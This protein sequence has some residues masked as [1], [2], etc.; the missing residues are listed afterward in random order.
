MAQPPNQ[1]CFPNNKKTKNGGFLSHHGVPPV[2][3][4][5]LVGFPL[6]K[7]I[8]RTGGSPWCERVTA[9]HGFRRMPRFRFRPTGLPLGIIINHWSTI[10]KITM[11]HMSHISCNIHFSGVFHCKP[12]IFIH[13]QMG[14]LPAPPA[15]P[16][17]PAELPNPL[18]RSARG[19]AEEAS[20]PL[21]PEW[22][23][24][25]GLEKWLVYVGLSGQILPKRWMR[26]GAGCCCLCYFFFMDPYWHHSPNCN[27]LPWPR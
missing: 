3:I 26:T 9:F 10:I 13:W 2:I 7:T 4:L 18:G 27:V 12:S 25:R 16:S 23:E 6:P 15:P 21:G 5:I 20:R 22:A 11:N 8:Q 24:I 1:F 17:F 19:A 14:K